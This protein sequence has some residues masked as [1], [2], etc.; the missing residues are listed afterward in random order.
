MKKKN[1]RMNNDAKTKEE[2]RVYWRVGAFELSQSSLSE[3]DTTASMIDVPK[4]TPISV[5]K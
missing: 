5:I 4:T 1:P 3:Q 2:L